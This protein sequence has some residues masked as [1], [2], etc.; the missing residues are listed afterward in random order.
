M[1]ACDS[2]FQ[3]KGFG[4]SI[5]KGLGV[6]SAKYFEPQTWTPLLMDDKGR[7]RYGKFVTA[8]M[9][10]FTFR[11]LGFLLEFLPRLNLFG[12]VTYVSQEYAL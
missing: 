12:V 6:I 1:Q 4:L 2:S 3:G 8:M 10:R 9:G 7:T 5:G 11:K